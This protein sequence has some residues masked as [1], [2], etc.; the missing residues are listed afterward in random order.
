MNGHSHR[1]A[2]AP[3]N[4]F[5][6]DSIKLNQL[7]EENARLKAELQHLREQQ[8][9]VAS[10]SDIILWGANAAFWNWDYKTGRVQCSDNKLDFLGFQK[11][12]FDAHIEFF[13]KRIHPED[14]KQTMDSMGAMLKGKTK[15]WECEYRIR[16]KDGIYIWFQDKGKIAEWDKDGRPLRI[17]GVT[18]HISTKREYISSLKESEARYRSLFENSAMGIRIVDEEGQ[19][20]GEN[21]SLVKLTGYTAQETIGKHIWDVVLRQTPPEKRTDELRQKLEKG[22]R[23]ALITGTFGLDHEP[24]KQTL[25]T[26]SGEER[27]VSASYFHIQTEG[28]YLYY[29]IITDITEQERNKQN[30]LKEKEY[31]N[32]IL[33][34]TNAGTWRWN[35]QSGETIFNDRWAEMLGY[36]LNEIKPEIQSWAKNVHPDDLVKCNELLQ[37]HFNKQLDYY[38][39]EFRMKHKK[40]HWVWVHARGKLIDRTKEDKPLL[41]FGTHLDIT[42]RKLNEIKLKEQFAE[43]EAINKNIR[44][45]TWRLT[46]SPDGSLLKGT[47]SPV[48]DELLG[49]KDDAINNDYTKFFSFVHPDYHDVMMKKIKEGLGRPGQTVHFEYKVLKADGSEAWFSSVGTAVDEDGVLVGYGTTIDVTEKKQAETE[50]EQLLALI[51]NS[52][53]IIVV[54]DKDRRV[55]A[56]NMSFVKASGQKSI[57]DMIGKTDAEIFGVPEDSEPVSSY[58]KDDLAALKM[59][60]GEII[61]REEPVIFPD[62]QKRIFLT[63]KFPIYSKD[64]KTVSIGVV[65][66]DISKIRKAEEKLVESEQS[67]RTLFNA[68]E[69]IVF[70][71]DYNGTYLNIAPTSTQL[72]YQEAGQMLGKTLFDAFEKPVAEK[73]LNF[74]RSVL[75]ENATKTIE[76]PLFIN[77]KTLWFSGKGTPKSENTILYI[78]HEITARK[79]AEERINMLNERM[80]IAADAAGTGIWDYDL[81]NDVLIWDDWMFRIYGVQPGQFNG[82]F[83][84]WRNMVHPDDRKESQ[85]KV[86]RAVVEKKI[87]DF[88]FRIVRPDGE[89]RFVRAFAQIKFNEEGKALRLIGS[90]HDITEQKKYEERIVLFKKAVEQ[91]P[92]SIVMTDPE[93]NIN[94]VNAGFESVTGYKRIEVLGQNP[95]ILKSGK[96]DFDFYKELWDTIKSG[97]IWDGE[98]QNKKKNGAL[99]WEKAIISPVINERNEI[100]HFVAVKEDITHIKSMQDQLIH[101]LSL[102][103]ILTKI[104]SS[105]INIPVKNRVQAINGAL[106]ELGMLVEASRAAIFEYD[107]NRQLTN[108]TFEWHLEDLPPQKDKLQGIPLNV[109]PDWVSAHR[110][111]ETVLIPDVM[112]LPGDS[113]LKRMLEEW[114]IRSLITVPMVSNDA[115]VGFLGFTYSDTTRQFTDKE[116]AILKLF[117]QIVVNLENRYRVEKSLT[118]AKIKAEESDRLK[119][120]FLANMSHEIRTPLNGILGFL[121]LLD[122]PNLDA[123]NRDEFVDI[124]QKSS[125]RLL[126]TMRDIIEISRIETGQVSV[127]YKEFDVFAL[128]QRLYN[129]FQQGARAKGLQLHM[130]NGQSEDC[131]LYIT[132]DFNKLLAVLTNLLKNAIKYTLEGEIKFGC[133]RRDTAI[134]F[135]VHDSGIGVPD[136]R[137]EAIFN[138]FEQADIEDTRVFEG[139]GLGLAISKFYVEQLGG[140]IWVDSQEEIPE[141]NISG[142]SRFA[143]TIPLAMQADVPEVSREAAQQKNIPDQGDILLKNATVLLV[144]D[145]PSSIDFLEFVLKRTVQK[146]ITVKSGNEAVE[147]FKNTPQIDL[148]LMDLKL[149]GIS[150]FEATKTIR[151]LDKKVP[152]IAQTAFAMPGDKEKA[153][154]AGCNAYLSKPIKKEKL[155]RQMSELLLNVQK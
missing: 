72:M 41:M 76:Y 80:K 67:L 92:V 52:D 90:N 13:I 58:T 110:K 89:I 136:D 1:H 27:V 47:I 87:L 25:I 120:A 12:E 38:D 48:A 119:S 85:R 9:M 94:Y 49:L 115:C 100:T 143:F 150:G 133:I 146:V 83:D 59:N 51:E 20:I 68:M 139:S 50:R 45:V 62:G 155:I 96:Q 148:I 84:F 44:I 77:G 107:F 42:G 88:S 24:K 79:Q 69:D 39:V 102:Q 8:N 116:Q 126:N 3:A 5:L 123:Q 131:P 95:R 55:R 153:L 75:D 142:W 19:V 137:K 105:Y 22:I 29:G 152:I 53:D 64:S 111:G 141:Q 4:Y 99:F 135:Y 144:E 14:Y 60:K 113:P 2:F 40:G 36:S 16:R 11:E 127:R 124:I 35:V 63:R 70:E 21:E 149:P 130:G 37:K 147:A 117:A 54:K 154:L 134:E 82:K 145:E 65:S 57:A 7:Q 78:A 91:S 6:M 122:D 101:I 128:M 86:E 28:R 73:F 10:H 46:F 118:E 71:M 114:G 66:T 129:S 138:R 30:L 106:K 23:I 32:N 103:D 109:V 61:V 31:Q 151:A 81:I 108:I 26:K 17:V 140:K 104:S 125:D 56:T 121:D 93:G 18:N 112:N 132:S 34:G 97:K 33:K 74:V 98:F 43:L 15:S